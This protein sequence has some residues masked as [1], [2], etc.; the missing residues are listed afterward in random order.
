[1]LKNIHPLLNGELLNV[2]RTMGHGDDIALVDR[3]FPAVSIANGK[4]IIRLDGIGVNEAAEAILSVLPLDHFVKNPVQRME[5][6]GEGPE[7]MPDVQKEMAA[8]L[9]TVEGDSDSAE[10]ASLGRFDF[11]EHA[12]NAFA[13]VVTGESRGYGCFLLKKGVIFA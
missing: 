7:V 9:K 13:V 3:N 2:L 5:V 4:P 11:Y 8:L 1:M 6:V 10:M 12:K